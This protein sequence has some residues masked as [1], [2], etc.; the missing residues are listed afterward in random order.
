MLAQE[1]SAAIRGALG[2]LVAE[3]LVS[4]PGGV[5]EQV[6]VRRARRARRPGHADYTSTLALQV[7][8]RRGTDARVLAERVAQRLRADGRIA[9]VEVAGPGF[10]NIIVAAEAIGRVVDDVITAGA[11][12]GRSEECA[13][14]RV[15]IGSVAAEGDPPLEVARREAVADALSR[16]VTWCGAEVVRTPARSVA[17]AR[18]APVRTTDGEV[19]TLDRL[20]Q[21][22]GPDAA[23]YALLR[24]TGEAALDLDLDRWSR[25]ASDNPVY[26]VQYAHSRTVAL[27]HNA[28]DLGLAGDGDTVLLTDGHERDLLWAL[29]DFPA[30]VGEAGRRREPHR[31]A[32]HLERTADAYHRFS[33]H[34]RVLPSGDEPASDRHRARLR[35]VEATGIVLAN[36]L[37][38]LGVTAPARM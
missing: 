27:R 6:R 32:H 30:V 16:I 29:A 13:G 14:E 8:E 2:D 25:A 4:L 7:A 37:G 15:R 1:L 19:L 24:H 17:D 23:R 3:G 10:V 31:V 9:G 18:P 35:L 33:A 5:P 36:G 12:Y 34:V 21:I 22:V 20:V 28:R 11:A 38:L 26:D